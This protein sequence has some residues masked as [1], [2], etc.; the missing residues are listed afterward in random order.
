MNSP[1]NEKIEIRK[2]EDNVLRLE[3]E[4]ESAREENDQIKESLQD[5]EVRIDVQS[6][7][8]QCLKETLE[9]VEKENNLRQSRDKQEKDEILGKMSLNKEA[10]ERIKKEKDNH[11][12]KL[13]MEFENLKKEKIAVEEKMKISIEK[14]QKEN[15]QLNQTW[16]RNYKQAQEQL[17]QK[18][19][20]QIEDLI[21]EKEAAGTQLSDLQ[22]QLADVQSS[23]K[24]TNLLKEDRKHLA[25]Q[26]SELTTNNENLVQERRKLVDKNDAL[27]E[28]LQHL[29]TQVETLAVQ[30]NDAEL[31]NFSFV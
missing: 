27:K 11:Y 13:M 10:E 4:L 16:E 26:V 29:I 8:I 30:L 18:L 28:S 24:A 22:Q 25:Q 6:V 12:T 2:L 1:G 23:I 3:K 7:Q 9:T 14:L 19:Q 20:K 5:K 17:E 21:K 15:K 31:T